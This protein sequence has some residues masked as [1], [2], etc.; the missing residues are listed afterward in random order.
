MKKVILA[1]AAMA[2]STAVYAA[3]VTNTTYINGKTIVCTTCCYAG[4]C[5]TTCY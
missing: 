4:N 2:I 5:Q 3:C 1:I